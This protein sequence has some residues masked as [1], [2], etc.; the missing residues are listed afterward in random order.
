[1]NPHATALDHIRHLSQA[2]QPGAADA[3]AR[4]LDEAGTYQ[5]LDAISF[6]EQVARILYEPEEGA[7]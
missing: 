4:Q 1:M 2:F 3:V 5:L 7:S 6:L